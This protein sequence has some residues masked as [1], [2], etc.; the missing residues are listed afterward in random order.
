M[1]YFNELREVPYDA[2]LMFDIVADVESYPQFLPWCVGARVGERRQSGPD[3][4]IERDELMVGFKAFRERYT[5]EV[6]LD[7]GQMTITAVHVA[8]PFKH[9]N[10]RWTFVP[11]AGQ[12]TTVGFTLDFAFGNPVLAYVAERFF[13]EAARKMIAAFE[14]RAAALG[15]LP[16]S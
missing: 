12:M 15:R 14:A 10:S 4:I 6:T 9:L 11:T 8:G 3:V 2:G 5:S 7:R 13:S 16:I 1:P